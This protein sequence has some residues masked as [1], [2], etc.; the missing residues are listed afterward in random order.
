ML[1]ERGQQVVSN[2]E[3]SRPCVELPGQHCVYVGHKKVHAHRMA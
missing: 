3:L 2:H 1:T